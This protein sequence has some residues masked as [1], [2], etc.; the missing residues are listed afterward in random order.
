MTIDAHDEMTYLRAL[1][2][3]KHRWWTVLP[4]RYDH[5]C[6]RWDDVLMCSEQF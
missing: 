6:S 3:F 2:S 1:S 5:R 4:A